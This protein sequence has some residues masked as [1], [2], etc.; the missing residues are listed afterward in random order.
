MPSSQNL[1]NA[2]TALPSADELKLLLKV[3]K[4]PT[5][6]PEAL[7]AAATTS[8]KLRKNVIQRL[9]RRL[10]DI[11]TEA[12]TAESE[13][14]AATAEV[15][16]TIDRINM[17]EEQLGSLSSQEERSKRDAI[18]TQRRRVNKSVAV[19]AAKEKNSPK[20]NLKSGV[21]SGVNAKM[22]K[23]RAKAAAKA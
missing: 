13:A 8:T 1:P 19:Q 2:T 10:A 23:K 11:R 9:K 7:C 6:S 22:V 17:L 21:H 15:H 16:M 12:E 5:A 20:A 14:H 18:E 4:D 3:I